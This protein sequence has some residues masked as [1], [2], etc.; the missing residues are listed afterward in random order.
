MVALLLTN[1]SIIILNYNNMQVI[2][3]IH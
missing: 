1:L 2:F 3:I